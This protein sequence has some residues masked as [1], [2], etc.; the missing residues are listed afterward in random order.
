MKRKWLRTGE[1]FFANL[2]WSNSISFSESVNPSRQ[3]GAA[4][5]SNEH[6]LGFVS[7]SLCD[8]FSIGVRCLM[9][10]II[11]TACNQSLL[12]NNNDPFKYF[13]LRHLVFSEYYTWVLISGLLEVFFPIPCTY[14][15]LP[16]DGMAKIYFYFLHGY[17]RSCNLSCLGPFFSHLLIPEE[18]KNHLVWA[19]I[20][21]RSTCVIC[22]QATALTTRPCLLGQAYLSWSAWEWSWLSNYY[23]CSKPPN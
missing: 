1:K 14:T 7:S 22:S 3:G 23:T 21:P 11:Q 5:V 10:S 6:G 17:A 20:Q 15:S 16:L 4:S 9:Y 2:C 19:E 13:N 18:R 8:A 12:F